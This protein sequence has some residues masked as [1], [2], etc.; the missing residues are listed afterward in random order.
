[1]ASRTWRILR[2]PGLAA[3]AAFLLLVGLAWW[4]YADRLVERTVEDVGA[5]L[6]GARVDV[7][8]ADVRPT[9]GSIRLTGLQVTN[10]D[11]PM[12]NLLEA[13]E[14]LGDLM[15][16]PL[17]R[18]KIV[19]QRLAVRGVRFGTPRETSGALE[20]PDPEAGALWREVNAWADRI[21]I[22]TLSL[23]NLLGVVNTDAIDP[24][25]LETVRYAR[26]VATRADSMGRDWQARLQALDP[27][28]RIDSLRA[29]AERLEAFRPTPLNALRIPDLVRDGR[30]ALNELTALQ[31]DVA[32][33]DDAVREGLDSLA[34]GGD[35]VDRLR[36]QDLAY[37]RGL[38]NIPTLSAPEI[39]PALFGGTALA[40]MK[41]VLYWARAAERLLPP[42]LDPRN[43]PGPKRA[44]AE[45][46]T[47]DFRRGAEYPSFLLQQG[48]L[49]LEIGGTGAAAG[50]YT[51]HVRQLTSSPALL[52]QPME[53][54]LEREGAVRGP[55]GLSLSAV[56]DHTGPVL[57]DSVSLSATGI[58]LPEVD[59]GV[60]GG[61]L[62]LG[63]GRSDF[64]LRR[65]GGRLDARLRW[66]SSDLQW[67]RTPD[68][69]ATA[70]AGEVRPGSAAWARALV[71]RTL[72]G[73]GEVE[74]DMGLTGTIERP[75][76][77]MSS[78][79]GQAVAE[80]LRRE[81]GE[82]IEAAEA[83]VRAEV[84]RQVGPVVQ[85][86]RGRVEDVRT[87]VGER[88]AAQRQELADLRA[89]LE[90][91]IQELVGRGSAPGP[92]N[93]ER[94]APPVPRPDTAPR[95]VPRCAPASDRPPAVARA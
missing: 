66:V 35:V 86:A 87:G 22:P 94:A 59:L 64:M 4:L 8:S 56:L 23:D 80:S 11:R 31:A 53:I 13:E 65:V 88:V 54:T 83:S 6:V 46:I 34:I 70:P 67:T 16:E 74:L 72:G 14:I 28:P 1:M 68:E 49:D 90:A 36:A 27:R 55:R 52:G 10:P 43:R 57:R 92:D 77:S 44:R 39:T 45:G 58:G 38:L 69:E 3:F 79:L 51:A 32:A 73:V 50:A 20:N 93:G 26:R 78:N 5:S 60:L 42:G 71:W 19:V 18:K 63:E 12:R 48:D 81:L 24:D 89:R 75:S 7:A 47:V 2:P 17:L 62:G 25:S 29:V 21:E 91:R 40:W 9:E 61:R 95:A 30:G 33:L 15:L 82:E 76:L 37:V 41:P 85:E 84:E